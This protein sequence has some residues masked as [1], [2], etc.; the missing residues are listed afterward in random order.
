[1]LLN[2]LD[3]TLNITL[4]FSDVGDTSHQCWHVRDIWEGKDLGRFELSF[5]AS[6]VSAHGSRLLRLSKPERCSQP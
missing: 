1:M 5:N 4:R 2:R 3:V 6:S